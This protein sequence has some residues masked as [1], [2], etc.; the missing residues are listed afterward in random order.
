MQRRENWVDVAKG[1][2]IILVV[3]G[4]VARGL[5]NSGTPMPLE[6]YRLAD[7]IV[8]SFHMPLFFFISGLFFLE[9]F[10]KRGGWGVIFSKVDTILYPYLIWSLLQGSIE[11]WLSK[12]TN[13]S[14]SYD[15]VLAL[16]WA[17]QDQFWFLYYLFIFF[18]LAVLFFSV[19]PRTFLIL[20]LLLSAMFYCSAFHV[21][22]FQN[23]LVFFLLG[24]AFEKYVEVKWLSSVGCAI[25]LGIGFIACQVAFHFYLNF[26]Y[27]DQGF[28]SLLLACESIAFVVSLSLVLSRCQNKILSIIG[29]ASMPIY[30]MH[31]LAGSG[32]RIGM[33]K[34]LHIDNWE[35]QIIVGCLVGL[36]LPQLI[37]TTL[38][39]LKINFA[40]SAPVCNGI[41]RLYKKMRA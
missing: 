13:R 40:V 9:S 29:L 39:R 1:I 38:S 3:Y 25:A 10:S 31:I 34:I 23:Y 30:L 15:Q 32:A 17:P 22:Y 27:L 36:L 37:M 41:F 18:I 11:V 28:F 21:A 16:L 33:K 8:Y 35:I 20:A 2:G 6:A 4:H 5:F 24:M 12:Y 14:V 7:S 19:V 26:T